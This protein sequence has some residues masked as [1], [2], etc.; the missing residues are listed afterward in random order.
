MRHWTSGITVITT[1]RDRGIHGVTARS[2]CSVS[3][4]P[5]LVLVCVDRRTRTHS[6]LETHASFVIHVLAEGQEEL[7]KRCAG[8]YGEVGNEL[9]GIAHR[10]GV[11]GAPILEECL[12]YMECRVVH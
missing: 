8:A 9:K 10:P 11:T 5:P 2:F 12:A 3:L 1:Q 7:S 6:L 4:T